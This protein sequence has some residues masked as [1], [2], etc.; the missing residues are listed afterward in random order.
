MSTKSV[1]PREQKHQFGMEL[2][3]RTP[4]TKHNYYSLYVTNLRVKCICRIWN[5]IVYCLFSWL[6]WCLGKAGDATG[7]ISMKQ[8]TTCIRNY[9]QAKKTLVEAL[10]K[11]EGF[12]VEAEKTYVNALHARVDQIAA[13]G[14]AIFVQNKEY[15]FKINKDTLLDAATVDLEKA[16]KQGI[17]LPASLRVTAKPQG[18]P[19]E[20]KQSPQPPAVEAPD[21]VAEAQWKRADDA[22]HQA[23]SKSPDI[24]L[25]PP[26]LID[27]YFS[28]FENYQKASLNPDIFFRLYSSFYSISCLRSTDDYLPVLP[29]LALRFELHKKDPQFLESYSSIVGDWFIAYTLQNPGFLAHV[30][31]PYVHLQ[32]FAA[33]MRKIYALVEP[34]K[35][36]D[37][38]VKRAVTILLSELS[39]SK[40]NAYA[41]W[42]RELTPQEALNPLAVQTKDLAD[43]LPCF[44]RNQ[45]VPR[46]LQFIERVLSYK[47]DTSTASSSTLA[48][49]PAPTEEPDPKV[50]AY[51]S[52]KK[53]LVEAFN[54]K[55][56]FE[57]IPS[58]CIEN[59]I[60]A[61]KA[62]GPQE[63]HTTL[64]G[65]KADF[66]LAG[67][68][69]SVYEFLKLKIL[70][71]KGLDIYTKEYLNQE[72]FDVIQTDLARGHASTWHPSVI[73]AGALQQRGLTSYE[74]FYFMIESLLDSFFD[75]S[76]DRR[77]FAKAQLKQ[78]LIRVHDS[79]RTS[80]K[81]FYDEYHKKAPAEITET[82]KYLVTI[83]ASLPHAANAPSFE[84]PSSTNPSDSE[85][86][87]NDALEM[88]IK[89][90]EVLAK[91]YAE[92]AGKQA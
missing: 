82:E 36:S 24:G 52:A 59:F 27:G 41:P 49:T 60:T 22:L 14:I 1:N 70:L 92:Q 87:I 44:G 71:A 51:T 17:A 73:I 91:I 58:A 6:G 3:T 61:L 72:I 69:K 75:S 80:Y 57:D 30:G 38:Y 21:L 84:L 25:V 23:L 74:G 54:L 63:A 85:A 26:A 68:Q 9:T 67:S 77:A 16:L 81:D 5:R 50:V 8:E 28:A 2:L 12:A 37:D 7:R 86:I 43:H 39:A 31:G 13:L 90:A 34:G 40:K 29:E 89:K 32:K 46:G 48:P 33:E 42:A 64:K 35:P 19:S 15:R 20:P 79:L 4:V 18:V 76:S 78:L 66:L 10:E 65:L 53:A 11:G 55:T 56:R 62:C 45:V 83:A 47:P 88:I